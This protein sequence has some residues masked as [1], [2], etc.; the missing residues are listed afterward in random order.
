LITPAVEAKPQFSFAEMPVTP[1]ADP[2]PV[3][4][5]DIV[6][7]LPTFVKSEVAVEA[8]PEGAVSP[9]N[10]CNVECKENEA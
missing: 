8:Q 9:G 10:N 4:V 6:T 5:T 1:A 3:D 2:S 7:D